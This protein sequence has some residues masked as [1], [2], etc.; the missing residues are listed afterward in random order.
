M[1]VIAIYR[2]KREKNENLRMMAIDN[3]DGTGAIWYNKEGIPCYKKGLTINQV[4]EMNKTLPMPYA[5]H[6]RITTVGHN[7]LLTHPYEVT[8]ESKLAMEGSADQL[9][10]HNGHWSDWNEAILNNALC[11]GVNPP[12]G[13]WSDSRAMAYLGGQVGTNVLKML[14]GQKIALFKKGRS[15]QVLGAGWS[16][17]KEILYSNKNWEPSYTKGVWR[18]RGYYYAGEK[19]N[20][21]ATVPGTN[22]SEEPNGNQET[23]E[24]EQAEIPGMT[25]YEWDPIKKEVIAMKDKKA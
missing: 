22:V 2:A 15:I 20:E 3:P 11:T 14:T 24:P 10:M 21:V 9:L 19:K 16:N 8:K 1:C 5:F 6:F 23:A 18:D 12:D 13:D 7:K 25:A 4:L 17:E